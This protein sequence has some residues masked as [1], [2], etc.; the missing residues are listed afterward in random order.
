MLN[1]SCGASRRNS[2]GLI[3]KRGDGAGGGT[4]DGRSIMGIVGWDERNGFLRYRF[5]LGG[6][7]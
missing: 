7:S 5:V 6:K 4:G 2:V 1:S 3:T